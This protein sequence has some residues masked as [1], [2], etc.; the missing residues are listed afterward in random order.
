[1]KPDGCVLDQAQLERLYARLEKPVYNV[2]YRWVWN[3]HDAQDITQEAFLRVWNMRARVQM[4]TVQPLIYR[5][6]LNLAANR[7]RSQRLWRLVTLEGWSES[8]GTTAPHPAETRQVQTAVRV[9]VD[10]LAEP[11]RKV[12]MLCELGGLSYAEVAE[13]LGIPEG[14]VGSR[15]HQ[16]LKRLRAQLGS[17]GSQELSP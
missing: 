14:T 9:A 7:R 5:V 17:F 3:A 12:I 1:M 16:A 11:L 15:R 10:G 4:E 8:A 2:V 6:A 13:V